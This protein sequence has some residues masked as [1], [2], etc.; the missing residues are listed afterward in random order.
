MGMWIVNKTKEETQMTFD[1]IDKNIKIV[2]YKVTF[3]VNDKSLLAPSS[4][5]KAILALLS[6]CPPGNDLELFDSIYHSLARSYKN[7]IEELEKI[8]GHKCESIYIIGGGANNKYLNKLVEQETGK[9]VVALPIEATALGNIKVQM[10]V[11]KEL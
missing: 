9:K 4:M 3:D 5:K 6:K 2:D 1:Y 10:K 7:A 11:S 8:V